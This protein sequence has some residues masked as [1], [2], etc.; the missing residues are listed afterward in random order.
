MPTSIAS[1]AER[2]KTGKGS[3]QL[4]GKSVTGGEWKPC[5]PSDSPLM[6]WSSLLSSVTG[7]AT[8]LA[9]QVSHTTFYGLV[10]DKVLAEADHCYVSQLT[11]LLLTAHLLTASA[12]P[13]A[14]RSPA[15]CS[16]GPLTCPQL[17]LTAPAYCLCS[18]LL[19]TAHLCWVSTAMYHCS[20]LCCYR[21][22]L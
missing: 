20:L 12:H 17:M 3:E 9:P 4:R 18:P 11:A 7:A 19:L 14:H 8:P 13:A 5:M 22:S 16:C 6:T 21:R 10:C 2:G 15:H 1:A